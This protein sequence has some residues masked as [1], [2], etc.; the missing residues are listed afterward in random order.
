VL[1]RA[2]TSHSFG[3]DPGL[4]G[5]VAAHTLDAGSR[6]AGAPITH[7][8]G[9]SSGV[10]GAH[11]NGHGSASPSR[12]SSGGGGDADTDHMYRELLRRLHEEQEQLGQVIDEPF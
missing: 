12:A 1:A 3:E 2:P 7:S 8:A 11:S 9:A 10:G 5:E 6:A 4:A